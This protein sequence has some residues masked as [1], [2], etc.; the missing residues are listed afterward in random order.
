MPTLDNFKNL[1][2]QR[3]KTIA[4]KITEISKISRENIR[5][6]ISSCLELL[7]KNNYKS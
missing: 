7:K 3:R 2:E 5:K 4:K 6:G 1:Q